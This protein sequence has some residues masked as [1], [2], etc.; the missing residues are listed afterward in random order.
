MPRR[1]SARGHSAP[2]EAGRGRCVWREA[3]TVVV[4]G[5][6][7]SPD[8]AVVDVG[9]VVP[10]RCPCRCVGL[11]SWRCFVLLPTPGDRWVRCGTCSPALRTADRCPGVA[12]LPRSLTVSV[13][14]RR[15]R[16]YTRGRPTHCARS[17]DTMQASIAGAA[18]AAPTSGWGLHHPQGTTCS[19]SWATSP[20]PPPLRPPFSTR[21][22]PV[23]PQPFRSRWPGSDRANA[24]ARAV[25]AHPRRVRGSG[26][27]WRPTPPHALTTSLRC[28]RRTSGGC[29][30]P[31]SR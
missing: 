15:T 8:R 10:C 2:S 18:R 23:R 13:G 20:V 17:S 26:P 6:D 7:G 14:A 3:G 12:P 25:S 16:N 4:V 30:G 29:C 19:G 31:A 1:A 11:P 22:S 21:S 28:V 9:A 27:P 5:P 24:P